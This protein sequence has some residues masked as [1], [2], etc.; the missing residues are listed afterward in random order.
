[1]SKGAR[2]LFA[3]VFLS[4]LVLA[5]RNAV[6]RAEGETERKLTLLCGDKATW[7]PSENHKDVLVKTEGSHCKVAF[8]AKCTDNAAPV[9]PSF[10]LAPENNK[11]FKCPA[12]KFITEVS[13]ECDAT[14]E[15]KNC[16]IEI[17]Q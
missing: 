8:A 3:V 15:D 14:T 1:M 17:K 2:I 13:V 7:Y 12:K 11:A 5:M 9:P 6:V 16:V 4:V 10:E